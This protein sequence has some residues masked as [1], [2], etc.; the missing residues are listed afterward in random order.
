MTP[1]ADPADSDNKLTDGATERPFDDLLEECLERLAEA[2]PVADPAELAGMLPTG[3]TVHAEGL[4]VEMIKLDMAA[5]A[6]SDVA[7]TLDRYFNALS[8]SISAERAPFDL[9]LEELQLRKECGVEPERNE[10]A[11]RFPQHHATLDRFLGVATA[12]GGAGRQAPP[13]EIAAGERVDE[14]LVVQTLGR[15]AFAQVYLA[16]QES[17]QRLVALKVSRAAAGEPQA[18]ARLDHPSIVRVYDQRQLDDDGVHLLYM[19]YLPGGTLSPVVRRAAQTTPAD[20]SGAMILEEVDERM[21]AAAQLAP[22]HSAARAWLAAASWPMAVAWLGA[23][24]AHALDAAH[25]QGVLHRDVKPAN[26]LLSAEGVPKLADFNVSAEADDAESAMGGSIGY[27]APEHLR[28]LTASRF[29]APTE[30]RESAD[31]YS[32]GVLLWELWQGRRPFEASGAAG[33]LNAAAL[34]QLESR[35]VPPLTPESNGSGSDRALEET[36]R[37]AISYDTEQRPRSGAELA[38]GLRL[39]MHP[40]AADLFDPKPRSLRRAALW[41]SPW[42]VA[43]LAV[44]LPNILAGVFNYFYNERVIIRRHPEM[45]ANFQLLATWVNSIA[46]P[47]GGVLTL[48]FT[49]PLAQAMA[50]VRAGRRVDAP[51]LD[52][53]VALCGRGAAIGGALWGFAGVIYPVVLRLWHPGF[54]P[55]EAFHF[56]LSLLVDGGIACVYPYFVL[57]LAVSLVYYPR[58]LRRSLHDPGFDRRF[59][60][61]RREA[62]G[63]LLAA[64]VIPLLAVAML[65]SRDVLARDILQTAVAATAVGLL[66]SFTAYQAVLSAW[67]RMGEVL[68]TR[69]AAAPGL[70]DSGATR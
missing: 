34:A 22:E 26:V 2:A 49:R 9:V 20:R 32:L 11:A 31:L 52:A 46:F 18:M 37:R 7:P 69:R 13:E 28:A 10:Y 55:D 4:L 29:D 61:V 50:D 45:Q 21:L 6:E 54:P 8:P 44:L 62:A 27:M 3:G 30:V 40:A 39:A 53:I 43:A 70:I 63:F 15:G 41:P 66:A 24:L 60:N 67:E 59:A 58:M 5:A 36:L 64:A 68:S 48:W 1:D 51:A 38:G 42:L 35:K 33:D 19:Q 47:L 12:T 57:L 25:A 17:M 65:A 14:F 16:R 23:Q 56:F